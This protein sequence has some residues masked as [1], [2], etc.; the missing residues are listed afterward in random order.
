M[1]TCLVTLA[2]KQNATV[3]VTIHQ[4]SSETFDLFTHCLTLGNGSTVYLGPRDGAITYFD[5]IGYPI[6]LR[7]NPCDFYLKLTSTD[8]DANKDEGRARLE[9]LI[10]KFSQSPEHVAINDDIKNNPISTSQKSASL[11]T[12]GFLQTTKYLVSR[13]FLNA[14]KNPLAYWIR[15]AMYVALAVLMGTT[16]IDMGLNQSAAQDRMAGLFFAVAFLSFMSVAGIP[17]F[18]EERVVFIRENA[19]NLY[20]VESYLLSNL[21]VSIPFIFIITI[22]FSSIS[23]FLMGLQPSGEKFC[24][25]VAFLFF[26]LMIAEAQTVMISVAVHIFVAA[27]AITAFTNGLWMIVQGFFVQKKNIPAFWKNSFHQVDFQKYAYELLITNEMS[28]LTF[29]CEDD[30]CACVIP[31]VAGDS[32]CTFTGEDVLHYFESGDVSYT[33]WLLIMAGIFIFFKAMTYILLKIQTR[34]NA[35]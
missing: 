8:F 26:A 15:V 30:G 21:L 19:N 10:T 13:T 5:R 3:I 31:S 2:Q 12:N 1:I 11:Q 24:I 25:F 23:Y 32:N 29:N 4:P 9:S 20:T 27:L 22:A 6:P 7:C 14:T 17:A 28:G 35:Y 18:L 16:W 34:K 33:D